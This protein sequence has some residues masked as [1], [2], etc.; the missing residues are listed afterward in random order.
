MLFLAGDIGGTKVDLALFEEH[1]QGLHRLRAQTFSS[2]AHTGLA[3]IVSDF[4]GP[5]PP[6]LDAAAF[7]VA[8]PVHAGR[9]RITNL[10][11]TIDAVDLRAQ[12]GTGAVA[13]I[14][15]LEAMAWGVLTLDDCD[16][17]VIN[18]GEKA[19]VLG[20]RAIPRRPLGRRTYRIRTQECAGSRPAGVSDRALWSR[21]LRTHRFG[22]WIGESV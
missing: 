6:R 8:G 14:N 2:A 13:V 3:G 21:Q 18:E 12:L 4:L 17:L 7:G 10:P 20:R 11:W 5:E 1:R 19:A 15:D 22:L 9:A 16:L